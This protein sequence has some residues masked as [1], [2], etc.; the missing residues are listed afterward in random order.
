MNT[1]FKQQATRP[2]WFRHI[3]ALVSIIVMRL[4][5]VRTICIIVGKDED[6]KYQRKYCM[7]SFN[8]PHIFPYQHEK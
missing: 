1:V 8:S 2:V 3:L 5:F 7:V 6:Q 4:Y